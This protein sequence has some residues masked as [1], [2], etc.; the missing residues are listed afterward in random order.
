MM[1]KEE[2]FEPSS[3]LRHSAELANTIATQV[4]TKPVLFIYSNG[5][6]D[7]RANYISVKIALIAVFCKLDLDY[8][9][10]VRTAPYDS[11]R[12][13]VERIMSI[14]NI[15]LQ[16]IALAQREMPQEIVEVEKCNSMKALRAVAERNQSLKEASLD[17][18]VPVKAVLTNIAN[19]L[20]LK[21]KKFHT[22]TA[23]SAREGY[24]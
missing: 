12:N 18:I 24:W 4:I 10:A 14:F 5:D 3:P 23:A 11:Y 6:P 2:A 22:F 20:E 8:L 13:H 17:S 21:G 7:H 16:A 1:F 19:R 15:G 9:C